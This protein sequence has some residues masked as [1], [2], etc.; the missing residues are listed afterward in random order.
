MA[1]SPTKYRRIALAHASAKMGLRHAFQE[2]ILERIGK[3]LRGHD[4][5]ITHEALPQRWVELIQY[6][7]EQ[8][9][10]RVQQAESQG[11]ERPH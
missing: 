8:E 1:T 9:R 6:L 2:T 3:T 10:T 4:E 7:N 5:D 11:R